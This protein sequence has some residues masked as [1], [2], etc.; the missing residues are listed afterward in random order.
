MKIRLWLVK[1]LLLQNEKYLLND[2]V[3][4]KISI[5]ERILVNEKSIDQDNVRKDISDYKTIKS[6]FPNK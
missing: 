1:K 3:E 2:A 5:L 4:L 6:I